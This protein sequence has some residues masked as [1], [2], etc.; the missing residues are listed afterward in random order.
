MSESAKTGIVT[1]AKRIQYINIMAFVLSVLLLLTN[2]I[3]NYALSDDIQAKAEQG[4]QITNVVVGCLVLVTMAGSFT[5]SITL[6]KTIKASRADGGGLKVLLFLL[7]I[8]S[9][10]FLI[11]YILSN[12]ANVADL[13]GNANAWKICALICLCMPVLTFI[14]GCIIY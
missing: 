14:F 9:T 6:R 2:V 1:Q 7:W 11:M 13:G 5:L 8:A 10:F 3:V 12:V 4:M